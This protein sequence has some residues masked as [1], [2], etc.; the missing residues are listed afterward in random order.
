MPPTYGAYYRNP[1]IYVINGR[2]AY[3]D[4]SGAFYGT[5]LGV[6]AVGAAIEINHDYALWA[7]SHQN[8]VGFQQW[9][10]DMMAQAAAGNDELRQ[11][12]AALDAQVAQLKAQNA[13]PMAAGALPEGVDPAVAVAPDTVLMATA[14]EGMGWF[15]W[16]L[17]VFGV[18]GGA[19]VI[20]A[21]M[22]AGRRRT[23]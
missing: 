5:L 12:V 7:Y 19:V 21:L 2:P 16:L 11:R 20:A 3:G 10:Q 1:P 17:I 14:D 18:I 15:T 13:T 23:I 22:L 4:Y 9:H 6:A 8:D